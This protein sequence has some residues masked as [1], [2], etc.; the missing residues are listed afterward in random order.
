MKKNDIIIFAII[1]IIAICGLFFIKSIQ[2]QPYDKIIRITVGSKIYKEIPLK[3]DTE[4]KINIETDHGW[5][6]LV[7][8]DGQVNI[9]DA[10]CPDKICVNTSVASQLGDMIVCLP[11]EVIVEIIPVK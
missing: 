5:N 6:L 10:S 9:K 1:F 4:E 8:K 3:T 2:E 11:H 7:I